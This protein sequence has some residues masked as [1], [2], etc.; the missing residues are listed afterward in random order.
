MRG[1]GASLLP[2]AFAA[3]SRFSLQAAGS[4]R[5]NDRELDGN[6]R[7]GARHRCASI[8]LRP[9]AHDSLGSLFPICFS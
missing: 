5:L 2:A 7:P 1:D 6:E 3:C 4:G 9:A 8:R